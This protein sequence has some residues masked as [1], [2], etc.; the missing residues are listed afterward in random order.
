MIKVG[1]LLTAEGVTAVIHE[2]VK[3]YS[4]MQLCCCCFFLSGVISI[5][6]A[7]SE[8]SSEDSK[9]GMS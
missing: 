2:G 9:D 3:P 8:L 5:E 1:P 6:H 4:L 7:Y